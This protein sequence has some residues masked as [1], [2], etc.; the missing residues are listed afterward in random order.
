VAIHKGDLVV[1]TD[2]TVRVYFGIPE[3]QVLLVIKN[4]Y[5]SRNSKKVHRAG[6]EIT[7]TSLVK[8]IDLMFNQNVLK[9]IPVR[10]VKRAGD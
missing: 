2:E 8:A 7:Y 1:V 5:E 4:P 6:K 3:N 10:A 9:C